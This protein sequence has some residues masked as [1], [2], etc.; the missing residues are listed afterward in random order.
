MS[1]LIYFISKRVLVCN[2]KYIHCRGFS[3]AS[4]E[5]YVL[6]RFIHWFHFTITPTAAMDGI[7]PP[8]D[9]ASLGTLAPTE[10]FA[11][12][13]AP[14]L[15]ITS[16]WAKKGNDPTLSTFRHSNATELLRANAVHAAAERRLWLRPWTG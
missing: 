10:S 4:G 9:L 8:A 11:S 12:Y 5:A 14:R 16:S 1:L 3:L 7:G 13:R 15:S 2:T 6:A